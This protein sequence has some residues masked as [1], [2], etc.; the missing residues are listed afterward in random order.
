VAGTLGGNG[1]LEDLAWAKASALSDLTLVDVTQ[2]VLKI[3][4][5]RWLSRAPI[6]AAPAKLLNYRK[7]I[8]TLSNRRG[9]SR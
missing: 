8:M 3:A 1:E 7:D 9:S 5:E 2:Y 4:L 6:G